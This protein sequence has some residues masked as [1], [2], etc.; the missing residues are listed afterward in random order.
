MRDRNIVNEE[1]EKETI[2]VKEKQ[3]STSHQHIIDG[4]FHKK[5]L[6]GFL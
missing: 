1:K 5:P 2:C 3:R 4:K 6:N